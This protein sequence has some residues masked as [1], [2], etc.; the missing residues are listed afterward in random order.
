MSRQKNEDDQSWMAYLNNAIVSSAEYLPNGITDF[1]KQWRS[2]A[3]AVIPSQ[4]SSNI[5]AISKIQGEF[6]VLVAS[7]DGY[8][9]I[10]NLD[11][12]NGGECECNYQH[13]LAKLSAETSN[14]PGN[15]PIL[16]NFGDDTDNDNNTDNEDNTNNDN[17]ID[18][19]DN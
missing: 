2:F 11:V 5:V 1:M 18:N 17:N 3:Y 4:S 15:D 9:Y 14:N 10:Y 19:N 13:E 8:L 16:I 12:N 7:A 6:K